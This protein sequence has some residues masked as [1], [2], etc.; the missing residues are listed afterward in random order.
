[1]VLAP[2][3]YGR[4]IVGLKVMLYNLKQVG[5]LPKSIGERVPLACNYVIQTRGQSSHT[6]FTVQKVFG[7]YWLSSHHT[8]AEH[9]QVNDA[10]LPVQACWVIVQPTLFVT[11]T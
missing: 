2:V 6:T 3:A 1:M 10:R 9:Q 8:L 11:A 4:P 5:P 7:E